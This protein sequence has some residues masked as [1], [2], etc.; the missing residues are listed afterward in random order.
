MLFDR[1][2][3]GGLLK[4]NWYCVN[5]SGAE[6]PRISL[7]RAFIYYGAAHTRGTPSKAWKMVTVSRIA[8]EVRSVD[9]GCYMISATALLR[10]ASRRQ[11]FS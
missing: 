4:A 11:G 7:A 6:L 2:E 8:L 1:Q 9:S 3:Y 10:G 5:G